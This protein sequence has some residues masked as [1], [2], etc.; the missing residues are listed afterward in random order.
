MSSCLMQHVWCNILKRIQSWW[1][2]TDMCLL[3]SGRLLITAPYSYRDQPLGPFR[4]ILHSA[5]SRTASPPCAAPAPCRQAP[6]HTQPV[7]SDGTSSQI[8]MHACLTASLLPGWKNGTFPAALFFA[9]CIA[10]RHAD[11]ADNHLIMTTCNRC[12]STTFFLVVKD[13]EW[14]P[15]DPSTLWE[16]RYLEARYRHDG[17]R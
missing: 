12:I 8:S 2:D 13:N 10:F 14:S 11:A 3:I 7:R 6:S 1:L 15:I 4:V 17:V 16:C 9:L 5:N